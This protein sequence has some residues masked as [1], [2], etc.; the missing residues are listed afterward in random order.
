MK[1]IWTILSGI[2]AVIAV[3]LSIFIFFHGETVK[4][5]DLEVT[6]ISRADLVNKEFEYQKSKIQ[7]SYDGKSIKNYS[8][9]QFR[10]EN[11]GRQPIQK[12]D[13]SQPLEI[14]L[15][16]TNEIVTAEKVYSDPEI[17]K[18]TTTI[19]QSSVKIASI[20]LNPTDWYILELGII[21]NS[22]SPPEVK[23]ILAR[24]SGIKNVKYNSKLKASSPNSSLSIIKFMIPVLSSLVAI[25]F[26]GQWIAIRR[27][28]RRRTMEDIVKTMPMEDIIRQFK[29]SHITP[30]KK[31]L[32]KD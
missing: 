8:L 6:L 23:N 16:G 27:E 26:S 14:H 7:I 31:N 22:A 25:M 17:L 4:R 18:V 13:F 15:K 1:N 29:V 11:T 24:I 28:R 21:P 9:L 32:S 19:L 3:G 20:L 2:A 5:K 12:E 10:V 30:T